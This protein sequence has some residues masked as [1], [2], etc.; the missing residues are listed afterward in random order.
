MIV[1]I[2]LGAIL[3]I[4]IVFRSGMKRGAMMTLVELEGR[5]CKEAKEVLDDL[6]RQREGRWWNKSI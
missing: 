1:V 5:G 2:I 6:E 4:E 3:V